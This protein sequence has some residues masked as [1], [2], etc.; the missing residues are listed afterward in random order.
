LHNVHN[1]LNP[2]QHQPG[3]HAIFLEC[4]NKPAYSSDAANRMKT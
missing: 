1:A 4:L 2:L 3:M